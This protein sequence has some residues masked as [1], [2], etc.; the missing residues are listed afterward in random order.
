MTT[1]QTIRDSYTE[2]NTQFII[3][4]ANGVILESDNVLFKCTAGET[5]LSLH[6]FFTDIEQNITDNLFEFTCVHLNIKKTTLI[7]DV[8]VK[9]K[10]DKL[11]VIITD[12]SKHYNSFQSLAQSRNETVI[13][14]EVIEIENYILNKRQAFKDEFIAN[15]NHELV[16]PILSILTFSNALKNTSLSTNQKDYLDIILSSGSILRAMANDIFDITK[17]ETGNLEINNKRFSLKRLIKVI[18]KDYAKRCLSKNLIFKTNYADD[19]PHYIV[20]DKLRIHQIL[21]NLLD[22]AL[23]YTHNGSI[24][25]SVEMVY[26][27]ARKLTFN[28]RVIDT[29][30]GIDTKHNA[31]VF[32]RFSRLETS[33]NI[34]GN[35]LGLSITKAILSLMQGEIHLKSTPS[36]GSTFTATLRVNT[37]LKVPNRKKESALN[38]ST[39]PKVKKDILLVED[40]HSDQLS[41]F[42]ILASTKAYFIDLTSNGSEAIKLQKQKKYDLILMDYNIGALNGLETSKTINK[43]K[44]AEEDKTPIILLT[45]NIIKAPI[46]DHYKPYLNDVLYKPFEPDTLI[47]RIEM[48]I[49]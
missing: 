43:D 4:D 45:A 31:F 24:T 21:T 7:C 33:K 11:V 20:S 44:D 49:K 38:V 23:K 15:F 39:T 22:N 25:L 14:S 5:L 12:F 47:E 32:E 6:P 37:P 18:S 28:I 36:S 27:H 17:I 42:K 40:S 34:P 1:L 29:G 46:L 2:K 9:F 35:G 19:M 10:A 41:L 8:T 30:V 26:K 48:H 13:T 3:A 16:T